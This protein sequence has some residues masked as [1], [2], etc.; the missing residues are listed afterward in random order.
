MGSSYLFERIWGNVTEAPFDG[1]VNVGIEA[2][3]T[4]VGIEAGLT[5]YWI[6]STGQFNS[7]A[8]IIEQLT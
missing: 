2:G 5:T 1:S 8:Y 3:L 4:T 6:N 7:S